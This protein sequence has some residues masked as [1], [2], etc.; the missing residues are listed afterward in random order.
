MKN[1]LEYDIQLSPWSDKLGIQVHKD[2]VPEE[3]TA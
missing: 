1:N 2:L 3:R